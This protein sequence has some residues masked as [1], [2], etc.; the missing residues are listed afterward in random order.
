M[1]SDSTLDSLS[2]PEQVVLLGLLTA[3][4]DGEVPIQTHNLRRRCERCLEDADA[5]VI[6]SLNEAD[7]MRSLYR[8]E[9]GG[10]VEE[11]ETAKTSP[12]GKGRPAYTVAEESEAI[13]EVVDGDLVGAV[14]D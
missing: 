5:D 6:G 4:R 3:K 8:L 7:V 11:V 14:F 1:A 2:L 10:V 12:T 13:L 9:D